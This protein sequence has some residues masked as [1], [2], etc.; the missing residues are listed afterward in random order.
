MQNCSGNPKLWNCYLYQPGQYYRDEKSGKWIK[1]DWVPE[2]LKFDLFFDAEPY[3]EDKIIYSTNY[4]V[5]ILDYKSKQITYEQFFD[6]PV[7][8]CKTGQ[9]EIAVGQTNGQVKVIDIIS[10]KIK[11]EYQLTNKL[12]GTIINTSLSEVRC[13]PNGD[14]LVATSSAGLVNISKAGVVTSYQHDAI[15]PASISSNNNYRVLT[16]SNGDILSGT[17]TS[18]LNIYNIYNK[19][20]GHTSIFND[21]KG[22][23]Y[24]S[25]LDEIV[26]DNNH[27]LWMGGYDRMIRWDK[28]KN[29]SHYYYCYLKNE[30]GDSRNLQIRSLCFDKSGKLWVSCFGD[31][32]AIFDEATG[33]FKRLRPDT[34]KAHALKSP[35]VFDLIAASDGNIWACTNDGIYSVNP[36]T[37]AITSFEKDPRFKRN[38]YQQNNGTL[39]RQ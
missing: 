21:T 33:T 24:D 28:K 30:S 19:Q 13:A 16:V 1:L 27:V 17:A 7:S 23:L 25:F 22:Q 4:L 18:G 15:N 10:K 5:A 6:A 3:S 35:W 34:S 20:A 14:I 39:R 26:E 38:R 36:S 37:L 32:I 11:R 31:G 2:K 29:Q 12:D 8:A 9:N